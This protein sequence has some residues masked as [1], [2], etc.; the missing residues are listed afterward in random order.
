MLKMKLSRGLAASF[1]ITASVIATLFC[2]AV[3]FS[4]L[5]FPPSHR[6][7]DQQGNYALEV[8]MGVGGNFIIAIILSVMLFFF[9]RKKLI[10]RNFH[11]AVFIT[12]SALTA[13]PPV[14]LLIFTVSE[15]YNPSIYI[16]S[17]ISALLAYISPII[18]E[19]IF[20]RKNSTD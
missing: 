8:F 11:T 20:V 14:L 16:L 7:V 6:L 19:Y 5:L 15:A 4:Y 10:S 2:D 9:V 13:V 3:A 1:S 12:V 17:F 18:W